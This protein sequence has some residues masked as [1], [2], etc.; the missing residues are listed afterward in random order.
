[1]LSSLAAWPDVPHFDGIF[2][3]LNDAT[4]AWTKEQWVTDFQSMKD[5]G[6]TFFCVHHPASGIP[7]LVPERQR[8][9][10]C[11]RRN[12]CR[13]WPQRNVGEY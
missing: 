2:L 8:V 11:G 1:M 10:P 5:V 3:N 7:E 6:M 13:R 9:L 4:A 12:G